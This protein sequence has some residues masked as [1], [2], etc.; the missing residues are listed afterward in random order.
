MPLR[1][2]GTLALAVGIAGGF[3]YATF[4]KLQAQGSEPNLSRFD[5]ADPA[6]APAAKEKTET[7]ELI[8]EPQDETLAGLFQVPADMPDLAPP[9]AVPAAA[10]AGNPF[11]FAPN[12]AAANPFDATGPGAVAPAPVG[13]EAAVLPAQ[14][15]GG[16]WAN[17]KVKGP[18]ADTA[19]KPKSRFPAQPTYP[20]FP[21]KTPKEFFADPNA[22]DAV[23]Q[24]VEQAEPL[25]AAAAARNPLAAPVADAGA[26]TLVIPAE[27]EI[28]VPA[29]EASSRGP[30]MPVQFEP[31]IGSGSGAGA[32]PALQPPAFPPAQDNFGFADEAPAPASAPAARPAPGLPAGGSTV[33][34]FDL[35]PAP[36]Q[37][38]PQ[39]VPVFGN[40]P[41]EPAP[42]SLPQPAAR[43]PAAFDGGFDVAPAPAPALAPAPAGNAF[44]PRNAA[45]TPVP[46]AAPGLTQPPQWP[47]REAAPL[48][49]A[50]AGLTDPFGANGAPAGNGQYSGQETVYTAEAGD[51]YWTIS[52]KQYGMGRYFAAL[53]EY[54]KARIPDPRKLKPGMKVVIPTSAALTE[55]YAHLISGAEPSK[56]YAP[57]TADAAGGAIQQ[58]GFF[59]D[60]TGQPLYRVAEG[61]TLSDIAQSTLGRSSRW[62]QIYGLN[63]ENLK[64]PN[65]LKLGMVLRLPQDASGVQ[66][67][68]D[69]TVIR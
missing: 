22:K 6:A 58:V 26:A 13:A 1:V 16:Q 60:P 36:G 43:R 41:A 67:A 35:G 5:E 38:T 40:E 7:T 8:E 37:G 39:P 54:N 50:P 61:D 57:Q 23:P 64:T 30:V 33:P 27:A 66:A 28:V 69:T 31:A 55:K 25:P 63:R 11:E 45:P 44:A 68:P 21:P 29:G 14:P 17:R 53:A 2:A 65:D 52:R 62:V 24:P 9:P 48:S 42:A 56:A 3:G 19:A 47:A 4:N 32:P 10:P 20:S 46:S 15:S 51:N 34:S 12:T 59:V 18:P 49:A